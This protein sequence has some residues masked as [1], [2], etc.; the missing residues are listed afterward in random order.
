[1]TDLETEI[2][3]GMAFGIFIGLMGFTVVVGFALVAIGWWNIRRR[4]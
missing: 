2:A 4:R 3:R 1:M